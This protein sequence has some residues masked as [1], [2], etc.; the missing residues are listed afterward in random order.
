MQLAAVDQDLD[1]VAGDRAQD[2][3]GIDLVP[4]DGP[5]GDDGGRAGED[6]V[7]VGL[8]D[9]IRMRLDI[10]ALADDPLDDGRRPTSS[11]MALTVRPEPAETR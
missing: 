7:V 11:L 4:D 5:G 10:A 3:V 9:H 6:D 8:E 1:H 2:L